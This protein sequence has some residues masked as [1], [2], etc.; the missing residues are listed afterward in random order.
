MIIATAASLAAISFLLWLLFSLAVYALPFFAGVSAGMLAYSH[1]AGVIG[2]IAV[3]LLTGAL[4]L[5]LGQILFATV[6]S[7]PLRAAIAALYAAP[8]GV[9]GYSAVHGLSAIGGASEPWRIGFAL[10]GAVAVAAIAW[11]RVSA[12]YS[13]GASGAPF[14]RANLPRPLAGAANDG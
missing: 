12:L 2:A 11:A 1:G 4:T 8:A 6:R 5:V 9:A 14:A 13:G 7:A 10:V 3:A